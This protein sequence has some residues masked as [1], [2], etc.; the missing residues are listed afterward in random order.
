MR[1][2]GER[3]SGTSR[4]TER[5]AEIFDRSRR[6]SGSSECGR[7][8]AAQFLAGAGAKLELEAAAG[9]G[10]LDFVQRFFNSGGASLEH[11]NGLDGAVLEQ[12]LW[13]AV[14]SPEIDYVPVVE[15]LLR[16]GAKV[17]G[18][19]VDCWRGRAGRRET[20]SSRPRSAAKVAIGKIVA[21]I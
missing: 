14:N 6:E 16:A 5:F 19:S 13:S 17:E 2:R 9:V 8:P 18:A 12:A 11:G 15:F 1:R 4:R 21:T 3:S 10:R 20:S 7:G